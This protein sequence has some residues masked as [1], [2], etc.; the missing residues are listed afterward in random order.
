MSN[1]TTDTTKAHSWREREVFEYLAWAYGVDVSYVYLA[2]AGYLPVGE[3]RI[4]T[5]LPEENHSGPEAT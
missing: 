1:A 5:W 3:L 2:F 4:E